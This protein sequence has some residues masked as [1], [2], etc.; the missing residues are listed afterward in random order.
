MLLTNHSCLRQHGAPLI[1][2]VMCRFLT[3]MGRPCHASNGVLH[4]TYAES[5]C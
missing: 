2:V 3:R 1:R 5:L 4:D